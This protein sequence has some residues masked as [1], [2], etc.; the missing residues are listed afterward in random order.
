MLSHDCPSF[1]R[2]T[3]PF[4]RFPFFYTITLISHDYGIVVSSRNKKSPDGSH[5][6]GVVLYTLDLVIVWKMQ[7]KPLW[8]RYFGSQRGAKNKWRRLYHNL[9]Q[10]LVPE[11][12]VEPARCRHHWIL[13]NS[14]YPDGKRQKTA[15]ERKLTEAASPWFW[16][17]F[18]HFVH[19][20][21]HSLCGA[22]FWRTL[23]VSEKIGG[24]SEDIALF[25]KDT[26]HE[27]PR[28]IICGQKA[29]KTVLSSA[30]DKTN[31]KDC[32][33]C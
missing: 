27:Q 24:H 13:R 17:F 25:S 11:A 33:S 9:R 5:S 6:I 4:T 16:S 3:T 1:T 26:K 28:W 23:L 29:N 10:V 31:W 8:C 30:V 7:S 15:V 19:Q 18:R 14:E 20:K 22:R 2:F 32:M 21:F 12:G